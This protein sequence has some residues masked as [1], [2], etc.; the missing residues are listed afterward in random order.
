MCIGDHV[1]ILKL[2]YDHHFV[3]LEVH[4]DNYLTIVHYNGKESLDSFLIFPEIFISFGNYVVICGALFKLGA[5]FLAKVRKQKLKVDTKADKVQVL[6]YSSKETVFSIEEIVKRAN[7]KIGKNEYNLFWN[8]CESFI[9]W[10]IIGRQVSNQGK[11]AAV[12]GVVLLTLPILILG[13]A[14][15]ILLA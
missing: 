2:V 10:I 3:V 14:L 1:R 6:E 8:N 7:S 5:L 15:S 12:V 4:D 9:N 11:N 13:V